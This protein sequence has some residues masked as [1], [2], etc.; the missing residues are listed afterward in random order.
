MSQGWSLRPFPFS[1]K[2]YLRAWIKA[3]IDVIIAARAKSNLVIAFINFIIGL[4]CFFF[5]LI[6]YLLS[7]YIIA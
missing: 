6:C 4:L 2:I 1:V 7:D 3:A 5:L